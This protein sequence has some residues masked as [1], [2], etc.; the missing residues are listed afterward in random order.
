MEEEEMYKFENTDA[1]IEYY[2]ASSNICSVYEFDENFEKNCVI[3][4]GQLK[5]L[6][7]KPRYITVVI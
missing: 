1:T 4:L 5:H 6:F 3:A 2:M 7:G